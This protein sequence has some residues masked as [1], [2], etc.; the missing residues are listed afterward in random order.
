MVSLNIF[1]SRI[2]FIQGLRYGFPREMCQKDIGANGNISLQLMVPEKWFTYQNL[3]NFTTKT[4]L[5]T[6]CVDRDSYL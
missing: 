5:V 4:I 6:I 2:T 1:Y 3:Q